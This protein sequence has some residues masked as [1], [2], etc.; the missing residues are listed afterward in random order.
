MSFRVGLRKDRRNSVLISMVVLTNATVRGFQRISKNFWNRPTPLTDTST[1]TSRSGVEVLRFLTI[2]LINC[3]HL[4]RDF[5]ER[6][7]TFI[8]VCKIG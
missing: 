5:H 2:R 6:I 3:Q 1:R 4:T 7:L 8:A